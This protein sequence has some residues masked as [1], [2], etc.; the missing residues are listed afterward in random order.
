M[1]KTPV[2]QPPEQPKKPKSHL[3]QAR[4]AKTAERQ[5]WAFLLYEAMGASRTLSALT[6]VVRSL[7]IRRCGQKTLERWSR[8][9]HWQQRLME[10]Q[11]GREGL[12]T[13]TALDMKKAMEDRHVTVFT[14]IENLAREGLKYQFSEVAKRAA[15]GLPGLELEPELI[16]RLAEGA[17]RGERLARGEATS[18]AQV[19]V[20]VVGPLVRDIFAVFM[21][22]NV[23]TNDPIE[24][25][26]KR[27]AEFIKRGDE[28][29]GGYYL[30]EG[31][32]P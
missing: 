8:K 2:E 4:E 21:A 14:T 6:D 18:K 3:S 15:D 25:Q 11:A 12:V 16:L 20:Q 19:V 28:I 32:G 23:I 17:Q 9:Y 7:G 30:E 26:R 22:V 5:A 13:Q 24:L 29:L 1:A 31:T 27:Q 10:R